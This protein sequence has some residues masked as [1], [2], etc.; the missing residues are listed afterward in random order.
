M[1]AIKQLA[2]LQAALFLVY[3]QDHK[4]GK[5]YHGNGNHCDDD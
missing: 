2:S 5:A 3:L 1:L 4:H